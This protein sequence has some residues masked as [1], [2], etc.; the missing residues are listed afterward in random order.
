MKSMG[1]AGVFALT[2]P[3][4]LTAC[5]ESPRHLKQPAS[6][7]AP[8]DTS[9]STPAT[10]TGTT[11]FARQPDSSGH[12][13]LRIVNRRFLLTRLYERGTGESRPLV[14]ETIDE[15]CCLDGERDSW[16]TI[17]LEGWPSAEQAG[18]QPSW[19]ARFE[20]DLGEIWEEF[21]RGTLYGCCDETDALTF[22]NLHT[23]S[24]AFV[25][26]QQLAGRP[27]DLARLSV[28]NSALKRYAAFLDTY[29]EVHV[30]EA[31]HDSTVV[32]IL[33]YGSGREPAFRYVVRL[34]GG[35]GNNYRLDHI[36]FAVDGR[37]DRSGR[38]A[39][40][41]SANAKDDPS[42]LSGFQVV[43]GLAGMDQPDVTL[44]VPVVADQLQTSRA[45]TPPGWSVVPA[46]PVR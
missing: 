22:V 2:I 39:E 13:Q 6:V 7:A 20:G 28:P 15:H 18:P 11:T 21:Y 12:R 5:R 1:R 25:G 42:A 19:T 3:L 44:Q 41:W 17:T 46:P 23:G 27:T 4:A 37:P 38:D 26:S 8:R 14:R 45:A 40:L 9:V 29:T 36:A 32:G 31:G 30:P 10:L 43:I 33:Q 34:Q 24:V 16:A 35:A